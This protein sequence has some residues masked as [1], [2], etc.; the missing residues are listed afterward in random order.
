MPTY[1][2]LLQENAELRRRVAEQELQIA[3]LKRQVEE[4]KK[5]VEELRRRG[6]RQ[7]APFSKGEPSDDPKRPGRKAGDQYGQQATR[8]LPKQVDETIVVEC[9][10]SCEH[11]QGKV[12][13]EDEASQYHLPEIRPFTT[14]FI[15]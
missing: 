6:K 5:L 11:C 1:E 9:P 10:L 7:A 4:L 2:E 8:A 3:N 12:T 15:L 13:L 14:Q